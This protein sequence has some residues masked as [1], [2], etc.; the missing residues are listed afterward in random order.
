MFKRSILKNPKWRTAAILTSSS[1][2]A[3]GQR[4]ALISI[5]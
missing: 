2:M 3:E 4:D 5:D 1:A